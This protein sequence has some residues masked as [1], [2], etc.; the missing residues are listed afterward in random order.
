MI[1]Y[2]KADK[3]NYELSLSFSFA[4]HEPNNKTDNI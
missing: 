1:D 4:H 3:E 2:Q